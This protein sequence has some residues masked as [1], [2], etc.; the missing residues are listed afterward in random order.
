[1]TKE[2]YEIILK[3]LKQ[4]HESELKALAKEYAFSNST[5]KVG[6]II[7][8]TTGLSIKVEQ[9]RF[10]IDYFGNGP[11]CVY[12]GT[13]M[14]KNGKASKKYEMETIYQKYLKL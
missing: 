3:G 12:N 4:K 2:E 9:I 7:T 6:D 10:T 5:V 1:M 11:M 8:D 13:K 14:N